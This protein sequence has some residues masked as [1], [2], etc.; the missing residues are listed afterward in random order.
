MLAFSWFCRICKLYTAIRAFRWAPK[1]CS[2]G[3]PP[4]GQL[5]SYQLSRFLGGHLEVASYKTC[6]PTSSPLVPYAVAQCFSHRGC[7]RVYTRY[8]CVRVNSV[9]SR[10]V[11]VN[12]LLHPMIMHSAHDLLKQWSAIEIAGV[13]RVM[14]IK[15]AILTAPNSTLLTFL[16]IL[17]P[18]LLSSARAC[19]VERVKI[20][21]H[22]G[23]PFTPKFK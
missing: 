15:A 11:R 14:K 5:V 7:M 18:F 3:W 13:L 21:H 22:Y 9:Y 6:V 12:K 2:F 19:R 23:V 1:K 16:N 17:W 20:P 10:C 4:L 8:P